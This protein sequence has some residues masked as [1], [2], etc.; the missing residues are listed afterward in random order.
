MTGGPIDC[1]PGYTNIPNG[2][3]DLLKH[4]CPAGSWCGVTKEGAGFKTVCLPD[5]MSG[6]KDKGSACTSNSECK[7][8]MLC[9]QDHCTPFCCPKSHQPCGMGKCDVNVTFATDAKAMM[10][11]YLDTCELFKGNCKDKYQ[12]HI[13]DG[14]NCLAECDKPSPNQVKEGEKCMYRNDCGDSQ[15]CNKNAPDTGNCRYFC[16]TAKWMGLEPG[17]GGCPMGRK[18]TM[19]SS[20]CMN[21]GLCTP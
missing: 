10:C 13:T 16:D 6:L 1:E 19:I 18:C 2:G 17:K 7:P 8:G 15:L 11:S 12:C 9:V 5:S 14:P 4:D 20:G 3:C 21:L